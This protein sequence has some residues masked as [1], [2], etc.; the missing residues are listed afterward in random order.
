VHQD[1]VGHLEGR[2]DG[3]IVVEA[4]PF[5]YAMIG[6]LDRAAFVALGCNDLMQTLFAADWDQPRLRR[7]LDPYAPVLYRFL[8]QVA[9]SAEG[10]LDRVQVCGLLPQ[11]RGV[12]PLLLGLGY[13]AFSV[14]TVMI[15]WLARVVRTTRLSDAR[16]LVERACLSRNARELRALLNL[17]G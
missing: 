17:P 1:Q 12:L 14:D 15:P 5:S 7:Y 6:I 3:L 10:R 16:A 2:P 9:A 13:R 8:G 4:A 11:I